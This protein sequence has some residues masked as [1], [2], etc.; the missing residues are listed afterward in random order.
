MLS[1]VLCVALLFRSFAQLLGLTLTNAQESARLI[2]IEQGK[3]YTYTYV[4]VYVYVFPCRR[5]WHASSRSSRARRLGTHGGMCSVA[6][7]GHAM[8]YQCVECASRL[9]LACVCVG[10]G[11]VFC[12]WV[13]T[14]HCWLLYGYVLLLSH[15]WATAKCKW[16][17][18]CGLGKHL[19]CTVV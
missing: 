9:P 4:Y 11:C 2:T 18:P 6:W 5:S 14:R 19:Y 3:T 12:A 7:V 16:K 15:V 8:A 13:S 1:M 17:C 10:G